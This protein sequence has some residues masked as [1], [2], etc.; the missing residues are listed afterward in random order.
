VSVEVYCWNRWTELADRDDE[1]RPVTFVFD[2]G[3]G[4]SSAYLHLGAVGPQRV[5]WPPYCSLPEMP[6]RLP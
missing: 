6:P 1:D 5:E 4:A 2:G 3:P